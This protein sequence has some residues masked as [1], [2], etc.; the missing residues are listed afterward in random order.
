M[1]LPLKGVRVLDMTHVIAGPLASFYLAQMGAEVFKIERAD[2]GDIMRSGRDKRQGDTPDAFVALNAGKRSLTPDIRTP[3]GAAL[4]KEM[5][6]QCDVVIEN[7]RPGVV[8]RLGLDYA[9]LQQ[10]KPDIVYCSIS[11]YGQ[12]GEWAARGGYDHV[13]QAMTGMMMMSGDAD[14]PR[15]VKVGFPVIDVG[16][17]ML[18]ALSIL[19]ALH[20]R[21]ASGQG[22]YIDC[23]MVQASLMLMY[24]H[25]T[26]CLSGGLPPPRLGNRG[27]SGSPAADTYQ[28]L[29]GWIATGANTATQFR[30]LTALLGL[31]HLCDDERALDLEVFRSE[32]GFIVARDLPYLSAQLQAAFSQRSAHEMERLLNERGVPAAR[33]RTL[34]QFLDEMH[35]GAQVELPLRRYLQDGREVTTSGLGFRFATCEGDAAYPGAEHLGASNGACGE[36]ASPV[37]DGTGA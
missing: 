23:S 15:P 7:F 29:D 12:G 18:G 30:A 10:V 27:Y 21:S 14:D 3:E 19:A 33:V 1:Y 36:W 28:C 13:M 16:V 32:G 24:P 34:D 31:E 26:S 4:V 37:T 25:A 9:A 22:Q 35:S 2:D 8:A 5:V 11:G 20:G 17:G 6:R